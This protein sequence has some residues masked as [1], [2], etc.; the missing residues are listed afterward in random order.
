MAT[1]TDPATTLSIPGFT[2][3]VIMEAARKTSGVQYANVLDRAGLSRFRDHSPEPNGTPVATPLELKRMFTQFYEVLGEQVTRM[4]FRTW[5]REIAPYILAPQPW[6]DQMRAEVLSKPPAQ[7]LGALVHFIGELGNAYW[8][9]TRMTETDEAWYMT[10]TPCT[11]CLG[12]CELAAQLPPEK[13]PTRPICS[14]LEGVIPAIAYQV[15]KHRIVVTE[16]ACAAAGAPHCQ[17]AI[18]KPQPVSQLM[19]NGYQ[20][21]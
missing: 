2:M 13:R 11:I 6:G 20:A 14:N 9:P 18:Y 4:A 17:Y 5:G 15:L 12:I 7:Q 19:L 16:V 8:S 10:L 1:T 21:R 3:Y